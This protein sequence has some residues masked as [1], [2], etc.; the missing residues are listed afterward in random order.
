LAYG[1]FKAGRGNLA[2][3]FIDFQKQHQS[4]LDDFSLFVA[5]KKDQQGAPWYSWPTPL[6]ARD[7][8]ALKEARQT[9]TD[10]RG[11][12]ISI[13]NGLRKARGEYLCWTHTDMQTKPA[14]TLNALHL[15][16]KQPNPQKCFLKGN[17]KKRPFIDTF[18]QAGMSVFETL[19]LKQIL[20]DINAQPNL[21]HKSFLE[22][23]PSPPSDFSF[24]LYFYYLARKNNYS[25][26]RFPVLFPKRIHGESAW[27]TTLAGKWNFIKRT[28]R[29]TAQLKKK[30][31]HDSP[32]I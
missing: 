18:F 10:E 20:Y 26:I 29:F 19:I 17:R 22:K 6:I 11:Y 24:D 4:W 28:L 32:Q 30:I 3:R 27:N 15:I 21:F 1:H 31:K 8:A 12:G 7:P 23:I 14:D 5:I 25:V 2:A 16:K 13:F 9:L